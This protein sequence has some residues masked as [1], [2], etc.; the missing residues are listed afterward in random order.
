M[1]WVRFED[2][3]GDVP[4]LDNEDGD[5]EPLSEADVVEELEKLEESDSETK[6]DGTLL[7]KAKKKEEDDSARPANAFVDKSPARWQAQTGAFDTADKR[8]RRMVEKKQQNASQVQ[9]GK[10]HHVKD[11]ANGLS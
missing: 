4:G 1:E 3:L 6:S 2:T 7:E 5:D 8:V 9:A 11:S 10:G